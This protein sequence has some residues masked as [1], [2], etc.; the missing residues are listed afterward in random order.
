M[1][2]ALSA[3]FRLSVMLPV[4]PT[5]LLGTPALAPALLYSSCPLEPATN[6][7]VPVAS[8]NEMVRA[9]VGVMVCSVVV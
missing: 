8:G 2:V 3:P 9:A 5:T 1:P 4:A 7:T 6:A